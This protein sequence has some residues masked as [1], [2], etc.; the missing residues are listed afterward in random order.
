ML[1]LDRHV[2]QCITLYTP[3]GLKVTIKVVT[4]KRGQVK[5]GIDAPREVSVDREE[6]YYRKHPEMKPA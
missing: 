5:L 3:G 6:I 2:D 4:I 1:Y